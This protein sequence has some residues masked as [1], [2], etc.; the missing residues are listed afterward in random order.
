VNPPVLDQLLERH[1]GDLA[2]QSV[3]RRED[4]RLRR[5]VDD[6][7]DAGEVLERAD[8]AALAADDPTLHVVRR[9]LDDGHRGLGGVAGGD[10]LE[11]VG[12]QVAGAAACLGAGLLFLLADAERELVPDQVLRLL[13]QVLLRLRD[14]ERS[15][16]LEIGERLVPGGLELLLE[17]AHVHLSV[18]QA[19]LAPVELRRAQLHLV[20]GLRE[21]LL[22]LRHLLAPALHLGLDLGAEL[23]RELA[24]LDLRFPPDGLGLSLGDVDA[25]AA[26]EEQE[27]RRGARSESKSHERREQ[28]EHAGPASDWRRW[29][30]RGTSR[31]LALRVL[32]SGAPA[33]KPCS[34][35][36]ALDQANAGAS[37]WTP[38]RCD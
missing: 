5:V 25:G 9:E 11:R 13:E 17:L 36:G 28:R 24:R 31:G 12:D 22:D 16:P 4:D 32:T 15:G 29:I 14:R 2:T 10:A 30:G 38:V 27:Q 35:L 23:D 7:V 19:L 21:A 8:V 33:R 18:V 20:L 37:S 34:G 6:E 1:P 26:A 3:E